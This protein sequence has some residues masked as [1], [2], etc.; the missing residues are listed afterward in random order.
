[1]CSGAE[2]YYA[3]NIYT[4]E[5]Q[6]QCFARSIQN[7]LISEFNFLLP[8]SVSADAGITSSLP[9]QVSLASS[10]SLDLFDPLPTSTLISTNPTRKTPES[11]LGPNAALVNLD[12]LVTKPAQPAPVVNPFLAATGRSSEDFFFLETYCAMLKHSYIQIEYFL[13]LSRYANKREVK[14][15]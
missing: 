14:A 12:S 8:L 6:V 2:D 1:M 11:F 5:M 4:R 10:G 13:I 9:S 15:T 7:P 3:R